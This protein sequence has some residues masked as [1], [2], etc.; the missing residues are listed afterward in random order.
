MFELQPEFIDLDPRKNRPKQTKDDQGF[1]ILSYPVTI[2]FMNLRH[3][4][5]VPPEIIK[6]KTILDVGS[7]MGATGAWSLYHGAKDYTGVEIQKYYLNKS[8]ET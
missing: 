8:R 3:S 7:C 1:D 2:E 6:G 4:V 5:M